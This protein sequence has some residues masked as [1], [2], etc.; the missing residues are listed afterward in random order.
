MLNL[1]NQ[2]KS[3]EAKISQIQNGIYVELLLAM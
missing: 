3:A 2:Y 1:H